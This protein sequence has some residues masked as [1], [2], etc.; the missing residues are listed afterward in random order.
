VA[1]QDLSEIAQAVVGMKCVVL[2]QVAIKLDQ[3]PEGIEA[4]ELQ[5]R[6]GF[7]CML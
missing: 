4:M 2:R 7:V 1:E 6:S 5:A 3:I